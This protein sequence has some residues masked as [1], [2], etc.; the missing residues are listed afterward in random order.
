MKLIIENF[1]EFDDEDRTVSD[2]QSYEN[3]ERLFKALEQASETE[4]RLSPEDEQLVLSSIKR[5]N[6]YDL[7]YY[8][9]RA[10]KGRWPAFEEFMFNNFWKLGPHNFADYWDTCAMPFE[11]WTE[12]LPWPEFEDRIEQELEKGLGPTQKRMLLGMANAY[13]YR[14]RRR[15]W[16]EELLQLYRP[17]NFNRQVRP[18]R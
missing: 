17:P 4:V 5:E 8:I 11:T 15:K 16:Y 18:A 3:T 14:A 13:Q 1:D 2:T 6:F 7:R 12:S 10:I 9:R